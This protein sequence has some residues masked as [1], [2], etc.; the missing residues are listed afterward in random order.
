M[1]HI[2]CASFELPFDRGERF[3]R[4][5]ATTTEMLEYL[6]ERGILKRSG[7]RFHWMS[8]IYPANGISLRTAAHE[9]F[10]IVDNTD[11]S[12]VIGEIDYY[13]APTLIHDDAI[14]LHQGRQYYIDRLDWE[15]RMAFCHEVDSDYYTDAET[16]TDIHVLESNESRPLSGGTLSRGEINVRNMAVMFKKIK[17]NTHENLGWARFICRSRRCTR[18]RP[19]SISTRS[20]STPS[21]ENPSRRD[22]SIQSPTYCA[23]RSAV[24]AVRLRGHSRSPPDPV[25]LQR[26]TGRLPL[27]L[28]SRR[29]RHR[30]KGV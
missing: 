9:N 17:F 30:G 16:K 21:P 7:E 14:Y 20:A 5:L 10:V 6:E 22:S 2:K 28:R 11:H 19:G 12:R 1:D 25:E 8:D 27:R 24:H 18:H 4:H 26:K 3:A 23:Y 15:R 13:S 29:R